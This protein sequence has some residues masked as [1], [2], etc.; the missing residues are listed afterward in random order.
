MLK[1]RAAIIL[2]VADC[3]KPI[4]EDILDESY[5]CK[6]LYKSPRLLELVIE[7]D[8]GV[9][10]SRFMFDTDVDFSEF[11]PAQ[12]DVSSW[13]VMCVTIVD[14]YEGINNDVLEPVE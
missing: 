14:L 2:D 6:I 9:L 11:E 12:E 1:H 7:D 4:W 13:E 5:L 10:V 8:D 3:S